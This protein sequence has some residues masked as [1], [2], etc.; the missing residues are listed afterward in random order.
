M[1]VDL[2]VTHV[3]SIF[4]PSTRHQSIKPYDDCLPAM[5]SSFETTAAMIAEHRSGLAAG[6]R[7]GS[8][9]A[10]ILKKPVPPNR[11]RGV[12]VAGSEEPLTVAN[13]LKCNGVTSGHENGL[14]DYK[15]KPIAIKVG[16]SG[17]GSGEGGRVSSPHSPLLR[18]GFT[19]GL[20]SSSAPSHY[21]SGSS[22]TNGHHSHHDHNLIIDSEEEDEEIGLTGEGEDSVF[23]GVSPSVGPSQQT[24]SRPTVVGNGSSSSSVTN[25]VA[26]GTSN[27]TTKPTPILLVASR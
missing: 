7:G 22:I 3:Q 2:I 13:V 17:S 25:S 6:K 16:G 15:S 18:N 19:F 8:T 5:L 23:R 24:K 11:A 1:A 21:S 27:S 14:L 4:D 26:N 9:S 10:C 20:S 12:G